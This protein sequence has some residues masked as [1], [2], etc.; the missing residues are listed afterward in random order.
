MSYS[1]CCAQQAGRDGYLTVKAAPSFEDRLACFSQYAIEDQM[2]IYLYSQYN[3]EGGSD[4]FLRFMVNQGETK[5]PA[6][7]ARIDSDQ[8]R[9]LRSK[10]GLIQVLDYIDQGCKCLTGDEVAVLERN[11]SAV[12]DSDS[13]G[14]ASIKRLYVKFL[15]RI[16][17]RLATKKSQ[18]NA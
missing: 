10:V 17:S 15:D 16:R 6:I 3:I 7:V 2:N 9:D 13:P 14:T 11:Q 8:D 5:I 12:T 1:L 18:Q 4:E